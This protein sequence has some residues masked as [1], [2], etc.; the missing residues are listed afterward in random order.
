M[1]PLFAR[2]AL[3][4]LVLSKNFT[5]PAIDGEQLQKTSVLRITYRNFEARHA[6]C[7]FLD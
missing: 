7:F 4:F 1:R 6:Y 3:K 2:L 5:K